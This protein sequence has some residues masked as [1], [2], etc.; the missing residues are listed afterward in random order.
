[1]FTAS[2]LIYHS[3]IPIIDAQDAA[4]VVR[5]RLIGDLVAPL[6]GT[7][8][9]DDGGEACPGLPPEIDCS[10]VS[11]VLELGCGQGEWA[12]SLAYAHPELEV[13]GVEAHRVLVDSANQQACD[14]MLTNAS[15]GL[16]DFT[17]PPFDF[18]DA[19]FDLITAS[20]LSRYLEELQWPALIQECARLLKP[21]GWLRV[22]ECESGTSSS[23]TLEQL[24][25]HYSQALERAGL[26][27]I[28]PG[29][30]HDLRADSALRRMLGEAGLPVCATHRTTLD[31]SASQIETYAAMR[32]VITVFFE[33]VRPFVLRM[34]TVSEAEYASLVEQVGY[35]IRSPLFCGRW[36]LLTLWGKK[37]EA[38]KRMER[39]VIARRDAQGGARVDLT[40]N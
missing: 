9:P 11:H 3:T 26:H 12:L 17:H 24:S 39:A 37:A 28:P 1:M 22:V 15:F 23:P 29:R 16:V 10:Q 30:A 31:F 21:G 32:Q 19:S 40:T 18:S 13:A 14:Q 6:I 8:F 7:I 35:E 27:P 36:H 38:G 20:F 34:G 33:L 5:W 2:E 4:E 25:L